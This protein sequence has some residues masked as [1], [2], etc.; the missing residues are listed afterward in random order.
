MVEINLIPLASSLSSERLAKK[1][2]ELCSIIESDKEIKIFENKDALS[3]FLVLSGGSEKPF[4]DVYKN[5]KEPYVFILDQ[6]D[7]SLASTLEIISFLKEKKLSFEAIFTPIEESLAKVKS[8]AK[9]YKSIKEMRGDKLGVIGTPSDWLIASNVDYKRVKSIFGIELIDVPYD[10][11]LKA[12]DESVIDE[13]MVERF[14][15]KNAPEEEIK[16][17]LKIYSALLS[18]IKKYDLKGFTLR[19]F[20]LIDKIKATSCLAYAMLG[21]EGYVAACEGDVPA[22]I[23]MYVI[24]K[25]F[26]EPSFQAN[27]SYLN[28]DKLF[29][30]HCT[31]PFSMC[32]SYH[33][34]THF[35]SDISIGIKGELEKGDVTLFKFNNSFTRYLLTTGQIIDNHAKNNLCRTQIELEIKDIEKTILDSAVGNHL[36]LFYGRHEDEILS[37]LHLLG[38]R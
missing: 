37:L 38:L 3:V 24:K 10:E 13:K 8:L 20:D 28:G 35:E 18:I 4:K 15:N 2:D 14:K 34:H 27:P 26:D 17:A 22:L 9:L 23:T 25:V 12:V 30:A 6:N 36:C 7:N 29:L 33:F 21:E 1:K 31:I 32:S 11:F 5:Y 16:K 19:C